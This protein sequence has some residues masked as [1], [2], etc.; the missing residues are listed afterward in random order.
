MYI[1]IY[2]PKD[3]IPIPLADEGGTKEDAWFHYGID[4]CNDLILGAIPANDIYLVD[5]D[6][7]EILIFGAQAMRYL[8]DAHDGVQA[9]NGDGCFYMQGGLRSAYRSVCTIEKW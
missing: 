9:Y 7:D 5:T 6:R 1:Y 4:D 2:T 3:Y 8:W